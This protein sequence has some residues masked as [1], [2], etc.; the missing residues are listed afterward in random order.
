MAAAFVVTAARRV[1]RV[2]VAGPSMLPALEPGDRLLVVRGLRLREGEVVAVRDPHD[3]DRVLV[4]RATAV[5]PDG[6]VDVHGDNPG[7]STDSRDFGPVDRRLV[8][9]RAVYRYWPEERRGRLT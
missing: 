5:W 3:E 7:A 2:E 1:S 9:G 6:S 4:K 8:V